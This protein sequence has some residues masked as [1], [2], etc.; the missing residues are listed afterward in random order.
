MNRRPVGEFPGVKC[1]AAEGPSL[2]SQ[3]FSPA[4]LPAGELWHLQRCDMDK[5]LPATEKGGGGWQRR[6]RSDEERAASREEGLTTSNCWAREREANQV[7][8]CTRVCVCVCVCRR[9][10]VPGSAIWLLDRALLINREVNCCGSTQPVSNITPG[11]WRQQTSNMFVTT[12]TLS[13]CLNAKDVMNCC[14]D[15]KN[16]F[17]KVWV[18]DCIRV[19][20]CP[21][22]FL[23]YQ[24]ANSTSKVKTSLWSAAIL[25]DRLNFKGLFEG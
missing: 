8:E 3:V 16:Y 24:N 15:V 2:S 17:L 1:R 9:G 20:E 11:T 13:V 21:F 6:G 12:R 7:C 19:I 4:V 18:S 22:Y 25:A 10:S 5:Q 23:D 14:W